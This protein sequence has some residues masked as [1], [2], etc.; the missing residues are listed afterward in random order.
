MKDTDLYGYTYAS[1]PNN[2]RLMCYVIRHLTGHRENSLQMLI[3]HDGRENRHYVIKIIH[4]GLVLAS[5]IGIM[6]RLLVLG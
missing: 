5:G 4:V 3:A 1:M 2:N 6:L